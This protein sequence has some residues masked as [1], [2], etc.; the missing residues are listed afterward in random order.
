MKDKRFLGGNHNGF[1]RVNYWLS[2]PSKLFQ[3]TFEIQNVQYYLAFGVHG[4]FKQFPYL[5][6][7]GWV[8]ID[9]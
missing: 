7:L 6:F 2:K 4:N 5:T 3:D 9:T 8:A 1:C